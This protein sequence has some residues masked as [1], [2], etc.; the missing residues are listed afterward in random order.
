MLRTRGGGPPG[1]SPR[2]RGKLGLQ[3]GR[4][5][6]GRLIPACAGKTPGRTGR[7]PAGTAHP[8]VCGENW[9]T[10]TRSASTDG[11]S[12]RVRGKL[13]RRR[14]IHERLR[15]IPACAGKTRAASARGVR[16]TAHPRVC[17][18]NG[19]RD[20]VLAGLTG[21][22]PRVRGKLRA[23]V[24]GHAQAGLIPACAGKT[25][26]RVFW[27]M[28]PWAHPRVCG[29]NASFSCLTASTSGSSPRVRGKRSS[30]GQLGC[31]GGLIPA[32]AGKTGVR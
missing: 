3:L 29:E 26:S 12:P 24:H 17:G 19:E 30:A 1:S 11:S 7:G 21:S 6:R 28:Y 8:R 23:R 18:E 22:S 27:T 2:V 5:R 31:R 13:R 32:C 25:A 16:P 10:E 14:P 20:C 9:P 4:I 15:L